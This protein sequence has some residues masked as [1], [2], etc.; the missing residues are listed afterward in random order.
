MAILALL[1]CAG[2]ERAW[3]TGFLD[4][5]QV[6]RFQ[7]GSKRREIR[8]SLGVLIDEPEGIVG[9]TEPTREDLIVEYAETPIGPSD[10]LEVS[11]F[12][13]L[14][15]NVDFRVS[16]IVNE[17]GYI[18]LPQLGLIKVAGKTPR[19]FELELIDVL[20]Q[21]GQIAD[22]QVSVTVLQSQ[23][24][25]YTVIGSTGRPGIFSIPRPNFRLLDA[26]GDAGGVAPGIKTL[27]VV[28]TAQTE[29]KVTQE[30]ESLFRNQ[31]APPPPASG[32]AAPADG[33]APD[34]SEQN[35]AAPPPPQ[36][37]ILD[38]LEQPVPP[39]GTR[40]SAPAAPDAAAAP[41]LSTDAFQE[42][43]GTAPAGKAPPAD[44]DD[45]LVIEQVLPLPQGTAQGST[46]N[47]S[48]PPQPPPTGSG[49][50]DLDRAARPGGEDAPWV[51]DPAAGGYR[52]LPPTTA[53]TPAA[54]GASAPAAST[55]GAGGS[56]PGAAASKELDWG[57]L[58]EPEAV[59]RVI[60]VPVEPLINGDQR[61]NIAI[62]A[63]D[64]INIA[65]GPVGEF[66]VMG[67]VLRPG[68]Y[69]LSGR[70]IGVREAIAAAGGFNQIAMP[71]NAELI[72][73]GAGD[74]EEIIPIDLDAIFA[75]E[76]D[77]FF[78][79]PSD[80]INVGTNPLMPFIATVRNAFRVSY[81]FGFVYDRNFADIDSFAGQ[82][83]PNERE[84]ALELQRGFPP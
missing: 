27:Y 2:C 17:V 25:R 49:L 50:E 18:S 84:R 54:S 51:Y 70:D 10:V 57:E 61:Y 53:S 30:T 34:T 45:D 77:N 80:V 19:A 79:R 41:S 55:P 67:N 78:M 16:R 15:I 60:A 11:I 14:Q 82:S 42:T 48:P 37:G 39:A 1:S 83:N 36:S 21:T 47:A 13:L 5:A 9:A 64:V 31:T 56:A 63:N 66:Y 46:Q 23:Q 29:P 58:I 40:D 33:A 12:E 59:T 74:E 35:S 69:A 75:G 38:L 26:I 8:R 44:A 4:P 20:K 6:G 3:Y 71:S 72:R 52:P 7:T 62:R 43:P 81:G 68:A 73:R 76:A 24:K 22:P 28:R 65:A 32:A